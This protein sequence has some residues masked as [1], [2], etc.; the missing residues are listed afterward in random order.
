MGDLLRLKRLVETNGTCQR[1][2]R[3]VETKETCHDLQDLL[4]LL[5]R[6]V[7]DLGYM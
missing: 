6:P 2:R 3:P 1:L 4:T 5:V 7:R